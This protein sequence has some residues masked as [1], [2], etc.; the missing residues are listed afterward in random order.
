MF[1]YIY[2]LSAANIVVKYRTTAVLK[3]SFI[4]SLSRYLAVL[5]VFDHKDNKAVHI[6]SDVQNFA[7]FKQRS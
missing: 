2:Y 1:S 4:E 7:I 6:T 5:V 3:R